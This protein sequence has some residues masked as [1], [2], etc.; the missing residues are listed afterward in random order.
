MI[1]WTG[2]Q[3]ITGTVHAI[4]CLMGR[5]L[6]PP[7]LCALGSPWCSYKSLTNFIEL[8]EWFCSLKEVVFLVTDLSLLDD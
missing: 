3:G 1:A 5:G 4:S 6:L 8:A 7:V 2:V